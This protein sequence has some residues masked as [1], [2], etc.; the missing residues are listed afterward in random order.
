MEQSGCRLPSYAR[1]FTMQT[2]E[3][4]DVP[5]RDIITAIEKKVV[6]FFFKQY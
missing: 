2:L 1:I 3:H 4:E 6:N 5:Q